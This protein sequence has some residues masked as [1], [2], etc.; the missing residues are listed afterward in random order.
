MVIVVWLLGA[1]IAVIQAMP[2]N[3]VARIGRAFGWMAW[4]LDRRHRRVALRN[5]EMVF[6]SEKSPAELLAIA[7]ENFLRIGENYACGMKTASMSP[8]AMKE[9]LSW[10]HLTEALP[11]GDQSVIGAVGHFGNF[12]VFARVKD[13]AAGWTV[14]TTYRAL[15]QP[16]LNRLLQRVREATGARYFERRTEGAA[17]KAALGQGKMVLGLLADQH[18]GD[19]G[20]WLPFLGHEC[21]CSSAPALFALRYNTPLYVAV[22]YRIGLARWRIEVGTEIL[23]RTSD[24]EPRSLESITLEINRQF[25]AAIRRDPANWFWVHRRWKPLSPIQ[26][27]R[28]EKGGQAETS[29]SEDGA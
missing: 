12:E 22:C 27:A 17:L 16:S 23:T 8:E 21:S 14:G 24:G 9:R 11:Q 4:C 6:G 5:L 28:L 25:E 19:R 20:L 18:A 1:L 3:V 10:I 26:K 2:L 29:G 13:M 15:R 7:R